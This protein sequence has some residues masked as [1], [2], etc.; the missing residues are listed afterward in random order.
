MCHKSYIISSNWFRL[1]NKL[2]TSNSCAA[3]ILYTKEKLKTKSVF[4]Y[5]YYP[6]T[7]SNSTCSTK[8]NINFNSKIWKWVY[9]SHSLFLLLFDGEKKTS[10]KILIYFRQFNFI[11]H[12]TAV[13]YTTTSSLVNLAVW[14]HREHRKGS[15]KKDTKLTP[16]FLIGFEVQFKVKNKYIFG[17]RIANNKLKSLHRTQNR[18]KSFPHTQ[19]VL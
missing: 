4:W 9:K 1:R 5:D 19:D 6:N 18:W 14:E 8:K 10:K 7:S 12:K 16:N 13:S 17:I 2:Y 11:N 15:E 3:N